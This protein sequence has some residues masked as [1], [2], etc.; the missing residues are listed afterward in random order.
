M[1]CFK[2][3]DFGVFCYIAVENHDTFLLG[4]D[5]FNVSKS[6]VLIF[7]P[8]QPPLSPGKDSIPEKSLDSQVCDSKSGVFNLGCTLE[9][10]AF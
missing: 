10:E 3:L 8:M 9:T 1:I 7:I 6:V 2:P 4:S 5:T